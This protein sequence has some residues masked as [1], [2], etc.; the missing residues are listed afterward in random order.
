M[1][2]VQAPPL[3]SQIR[4]ARSNSEQAIALRALKDEIVGHI[5]RKE[6][7]VQN[8]IL[9][10]LVEMLQNNVPSTAR[11][12]GKELHQTGQPAVLSENEV[13]RLLCLQLIASFAYG[14]AVFFPPIY[15]AGVVPAVI[16]QISPADNPPQVVL[17]A[18]R[19]ISNITASAQLTTIGGG[20]TSSLSDSLFS[21]GSLDALRTILS[22][23]SSDAVIAEQKRRVASLISRLCKNP[24]HQNAL[25]DA[26]VL[27][28]LA[29]MLASLV[30]FRGEVVPGAE[31]VGQ[32]DGLADMIPEPAP[33]GADLALVLEALS[34]IVANSRFLSCS[35]L[36][37][38]AIM[39]V[40]PSTEFTPPAAESRAA[41]SAPEI[42]SFGGVRTKNPGAIDY[43]LPAVPVPQTKTHFRGLNDYPPLG[44]SLS[45]DNLAASGR[46]ST[47]RF[48]GVDLGRLDVP[49]E[50]EDNDELES[51][52]IPW[53][54][55][56]VR[57][58]DGLNR[59]MAAS[60][61]TSLFKAGF[62]SPE[63]EQ[64]LAFLVVP[65]L[66]QL[67][68]DHDKEVPASVQQAAFVEP[69]TATQWAIQER[70]PDVLARL[71]GDSEVLQQAAHDCGIIKNVAKLLKDSYEPHPVQSAP[72]PWSP[73]PERAA[74]SDKGLPTC[75]LGPT[76]QLPAM[77]HKIKIRENAIR[78]VAAMATL[79]K[80]YREALVE[81]DVVPYIVE[82]L[83]TSPGKPK[84]PK[85]K[86][87]SEKGPDGGDTGSASPY[88]PNSNAVIIAA[89]H[90]TR[91]LARLPSIVR[92]TLQDHGIAMPINKLLR[93]PDAE[94][95][96]AASSAVINLLT[97]C[98]PMVEPLLDA[99]IVK[100]LC[101][102]AHSLNP[103]LR[104]NALWALK[105]LVVN[106]DNNLRKQ[107]LEELE[108][109]WLVQLISDDT[110]EEE[111]FRAQAQSERRATTSPADDEDEDMEN[112]ETLYEDDVTHPWIWPAMAL[113]PATTAA[114]PRLQQASLKLGLLREAELS[115]A[116][117]CRA[118]TLAIQ[119]QG[120][121][122]IRNL[123]MLP[124][125]SN[126]TDMVDYLFTEL[127]QDR[128][129]GILADKLKVRVVGAFGR[130]GRSASTT[131][132]GGRSSGDTLVVYPQPRIVE[133]LTY[134][135]VHMA[136]GLPRHRQ[137]VVAQTELLRLLGGHF[138]SKDAGVRRALCQLFMNLSFLEGEADRGACSQ[139][140]MELERLGFLAKLEGLE[141]GDGDLDVRERAKAAV[142]QLKTPTV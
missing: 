84:S 102:H 90:A 92:T 15:A 122:F 21:S 16:S 78:L 111:A 128:L 129:F 20:C 106:L 114:T 38:P 139:R 23:G 26:G 43:L 62:A 101:E 9:E 31:L 137:L 53:L 29:T 89:C 33:P 28:A 13:V 8:G 87:A 67:L 46:S 98:S 108:P 97:N 103:G 93:H 95:Q 32:A 80:D 6:W 73:T 51:P 63:R 45:R 12:N 57:S 79:S 94:V 107:C 75:R 30:V 127:G 25:A 104:L 124:T 126:Q 119:E 136:A 34:T 115:P 76:G 130:R 59:V 70:I 24:R 11:S 66:C 27:D 36:F 72:R 54:I 58:T 47:F 123:L 64:A 132:G 3:L 4:V 69:D 17:M 138:N 81:A 35:L 68:K 105:H 99:G 71:V 65:L 125:P 41:W 55:H 110:S 83:S 18:L 42:N 134:I 77:A 14:G 74:E 49:D 117:K 85:E 52:L 2:R 88:G 141:R 135:L 22:Q 56:L 60:L 121:G 96:I 82:S 140:A 86:P 100:T 116:R 39:A 5:Q 40:F 131:R 133:N 19:A 112:T 1:A 50:E 118:D 91:A 61:L 120:L 109:G 142:A 44:F 113:I 10:P 37:S 48:M 7:W